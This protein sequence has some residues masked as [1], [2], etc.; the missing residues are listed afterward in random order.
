VEIG[1]YHYTEYHHEL[2]ED[3][4]QVLLSMVM[5]GRP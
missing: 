3:A 2:L 4:E 1:E 5:R